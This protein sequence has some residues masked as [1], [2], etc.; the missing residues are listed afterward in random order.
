MPCCRS[1]ASWACRFAP[2][3]SLMTRLNFAG[4]KVTWPA[5]TKEGLEDAAA[6]QRRYGLTPAR[7]H[8]G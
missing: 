2:S 3:S 5:G 1:V 4:N 8:R 7:S 6:V